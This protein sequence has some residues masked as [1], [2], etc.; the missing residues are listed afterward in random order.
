[1]DPQDQQDLKEQQEQLVC[2]DHLDPEEK[3]VCEES[4]DQAAHQVTH[5][6]KFNII[7]MNG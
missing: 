4:L 2:L 3:W 5:L 1:M 6:M 7:Y